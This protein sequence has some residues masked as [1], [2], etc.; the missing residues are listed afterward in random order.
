MRACT[1]FP[2]LTDSNRTIGDKSIGKL[3]SS[4]LSCTGQGHCLP[5]LEAGQCRWVTRDVQVM[6][7]QF[8]PPETSKGLH[9]TWGHGLGTTCTCSRFWYV[10]KWCGLQ[11]CS[12]AAPV[13]SMYI[14]IHSYIMT[15][16]QIYIL[17]IYI[18]VFYL[19]QLASSTMM[20]FA[21]DM[22]LCV[23]NYIIIHYIYVM[24]T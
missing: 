9:S 1:V 8:G 10:F 24:F 15:D 22:T 2:Q 23:H 11:L 4:R 18:Y 19:C 14:Y 5:R 12:Y 13:C 7:G 21:N 16:I 3:V 6:S 17:Y 20:L